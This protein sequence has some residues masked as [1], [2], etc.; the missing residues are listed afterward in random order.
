MQI[1]VTTESGGVFPLEVSLELTV[2]DL[3]SIVE[4]EAGVSAHQ[5]HL[6]HNM[7][8]M[9][10][11][12][13]SLG[14]YEV[15]DGDIIMVASPQEYPV[16]VSPQGNR[17]V[18]Q[19][20]PL[21]DWGSI[22]VPP[23]GNRAV[24]QAPTNPPLMDWGSIQVP[25]QGNRAVPQATPNPPLMDWGSIQIP[26]QGNRTVPQATPPRPNDPDTI[27]RHLLSNPSE[28]SLL[29]ERNPPLAQALDSGDPEVFRLALERQMRAT[30]DREMER[31]RMI[32]ADPFDADTQ[33]KIAQEIQQKNI[34]ENMEAAMEYTPESFSRIIM[35]Y[36]PIKVNGVTVKALVDSGA[37]STIM[38]DRCAERCGI[39]RLVDRRFAGVAVGVGRQNIIGKVHLG[40]IQIG[41][42]F[43]TSSF[44][45]L[46]AQSEDMLLG[47]DMLRRH[48]VRL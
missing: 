41:K 24:S 27:R 32:N 21:L 33:N 2:R 30:R 17:A 8:S 14:E 48:Q 3:K 26:P 37:A 19:P 43:L 29:R 5:I 1:T 13:K 11:E 42:D 46:E 12:S 40:T 6:L 31:I 22:Q 9:A 4:I 47:L 28:L 16:Q 23:Q 25:T 15:Q 44:Q 36:L 10:V 39:M 45:V 7:E 20:P 34:E 18:S 38:S 35:L